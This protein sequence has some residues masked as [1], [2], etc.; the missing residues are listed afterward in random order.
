MDQA[1]PSLIIK[2]GVLAKSVPM[3]SDGTYDLEGLHF[4][5]TPKSLDDSIK[6]HLEAESL[7][8][9]FPVFQRLLWMK[10]KS[11][12]IL[13]AL[14]IPFLEKLTQVD[15]FKHIYMTM[16]YRD[17]MLFFQTLLSLL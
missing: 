2:K 6:L 14:L 9:W 17:A 13:G 16:K 12:N 11:R 10:V 15:S 5:E 3:R 7:K 4:G 8:K 1:L